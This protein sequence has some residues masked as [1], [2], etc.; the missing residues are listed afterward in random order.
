MI[1]NPEQIKSM[2]AG[3]K[4]LGWVL[5]LT[6]QKVAPGISTLELDR[7]AYR[8]IIESGMQPAFLGYQGYRFTSCIS[9][10]D[11]VVHGIPDQTLLQ[12]GDLVGIDL[13][14]LYQGIYTDSALTVAVGKPTSEDARLLAVTQEALGLGIAAVKPGVHLGDVQAALQKPVEAARFGIVRDLCGHGIGTG[15]QM[16]PRIP[17]FGTPGKGIILK[18]GMALALEPMVTRGNFAVTTAPD[19]WSVVTV[20][21]SRAAHFEHTVLV[22]AAGVEVLTK[23]PPHATLNAYARVL[24]HRMS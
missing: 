17:N 14:V 13:G 22:T 5:A 12:P 6:A 18:P 21:G 10:N 23:R 20:D 8:L 2:R 1:L 3:G 19:D 11:V 15:L 7:F 16:E 24:G 4:V 9:V